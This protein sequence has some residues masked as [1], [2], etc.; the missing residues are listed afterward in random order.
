MTPNGIFYSHHSPSVSSNNW[1]RF[2]LFILL[3]PLIINILLPTHLELDSV[4]EPPALVTLV[5]SSFW[6]AAKRTGTFNEAI[7]KEALAVFTTQLLHRVLYKEAML[8]ESPENVLG[9]P[10]R[11]TRDQGW[12]KE[13]GVCVW[14]ARIKCLSSDWR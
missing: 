12:W 6:V 4:D 11:K 3:L 5:T 2:I 10:E 9:Y 14:D 7:G 8:V 1:H 13:F